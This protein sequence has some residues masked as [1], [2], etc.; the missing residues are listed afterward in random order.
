MKAH[1]FPLPTNDIVVQARLRQL[2]H[3]IQ[4]VGEDAGMR[5][6][7]LRELVTEYFLN[8]GESPNLKAFKRPIRDLADFVGP[9]TTP[10]EVKKVMLE[11]QIKVEVDGDVDMSEGEEAQLGGE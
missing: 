9:N 2:G 6:E 8:V 4:M 7:R 11:H 5:R 1:H 3:P 10:L